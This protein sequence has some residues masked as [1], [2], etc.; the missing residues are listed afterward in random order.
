MIPILYNQNETSFTSNGLGRLT[1]AISCEVTEERN[2]KYELVMVYPTNGIHY[3]DIA[4]GM[5]IAATH[6]DARDIQ[7]FIIYR[8]EEEIDGRV[9]INA[10]HL[11]YM[12][13][14]IV[15][16]P[17]TASSITM[18]MTKLGTESINTNPFTFWTDKSTVGSFEVDTPRGI[19]SL[20]GGA[21]GSILDVYGTGEYEFDKWD[22][23]LYQ[24]RGQATD[25]SIRYGVNMSDYQHNTDDSEAYNAVVPFWADEEGSAIVTLPEWYL[26][27]TGITP[28]RLRLF[29]MDL[30]ESFQSAPTEAQLRS[31]AQNRLDNSEAWIP[32][33]NFKVSFVQLWQTAEY[34]S[35][36][37]LQ[38]LNLCDSALVVYGGTTIREKVISATYDTLRDRYVEMELGEPKTS[39]ANM[40]LKEAA[41]IVTKAGVTKTALQEAIDY[42]TEMIQGGLGGHLVINTDSSG[43]PE[44]LLIMDTADTSTA[45]NVWR[46]NAGGLGHSHSGYNGPFNDVAL[47]ADGKIN[48]SMITTGILQAIKIVNGNNTFV[49]EADGRVSASAINIT[50]G[51]IN[52]TTTSSTQDKIILTWTN[53]TTH[54]NVQTML[55]PE[56]LIATGVDVNDPSVSTQTQYRSYGVFGYRNGIF[57]GALQPDSLRFNTDNQK[58]SMWLTKDMF[59]LYDETGTFAVMSLTRDGLALRDSSDSTKLKYYLAGS[60]LQLYDNDGAIRMML[61]KD[62]LTMLDSSGQILMSLSQSSL[63]LKNANNVTKAIYSNNISLYSDDHTE[64]IYIS[65]DAMRFYKQV[66][67]NSFLSKTII[68]KA[69]IDMFDDSGTLLFSVS[70]DDGSHN[71][72]RSAVPIEPMGNTS[73]NLGTDSSP[74]ASVIARNVELW[75]NTSVPTPFI[76]THYNGSQSDYTGRI[77]ESSSGHFTVYDSISGPS[78]ARLKENIADLTEAEKRLIMSLRAKTFNFKN[79]DVKHAG[80]IAQEVI[81][82]EKEQGIEESCLIRGTGEEIPDP[83]HP[84]KTTIDYYSVDYDSL[85]TLLLAQV[86]ELTKTV[87][88][89]KAKL[90][91]LEGGK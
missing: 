61:Q 73:V 74:W 51:S 8:I 7:P 63:I 67:T 32:A 59:M 33:E 62:I 2:G 85:T 79:T 87:E 13:N 18:V 11:S 72:V 26:T 38:R 86:Q 44:E 54:T 5:Y 34:E 66:G 48:A 37:V 65:Y 43:H 16:K 4:I 77:I 75:G 3:G 31:A 57:R 1:D 69:S 40:I 15:V 14:G 36:A 52:I 53:P 21:V 91:K 49:V 70:P 17:F 45:V 90:A 47:T 58:L 30:S 12:L 81:E 10:H 19:R 76:D 80:L 46:F 25:V 71:S 9:T 39:F 83:K 55:S 84:D 27:P 42:A 35:V 68:G 24:S 29:A 50:G 64:H 6:S 22:V 23:K 78:D 89:L 28:S 41:Q 88:D 56:Y 60:G 20:L 82:A